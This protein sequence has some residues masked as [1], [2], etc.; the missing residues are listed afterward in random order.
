MAE[1]AARRAA[2][3]KFARLAKRAGFC[4]AGYG[5]FIFIPPPPGGRGRFQQRVVFVSRY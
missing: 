2:H 1:G 4:R 5:N 3:F